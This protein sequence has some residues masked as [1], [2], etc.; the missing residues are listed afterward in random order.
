MQVYI[1][2]LRRTFGGGVEAI[3]SEAAGYRLDPE[4]PVDADQFEADLE[5]VTPDLDDVNAAERLR[6]ALNRW[7]GDAFVDLRDCSAIVPMAVRLDELRLRAMQAGTSGEFRRD[8]R[9]VISD[10]EQAVEANPLHEGFAAQLMSAQYRAGRQAD[11]LATYQALRRRLRDELGLEPGPAVRD[12]EGRI[13]RHEL[14]VAPPVATEVAERQR[15]RVTVL[16]LDMSVGAA[17]LPQT[18][19]DPEDELAL[20][21]PAAAGGGAPRSSTSAGSCSPRPAKG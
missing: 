21:S 14:T 16:S 3:R 15:R 11:A 19:L 4:L 12:L 8:P 10:L 13:L 9:A 2:R 20:V 6:S 7:R 1:T 5:L 17:G 18:S